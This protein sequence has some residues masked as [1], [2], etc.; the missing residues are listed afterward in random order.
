MLAFTTVPYVCIFS[1]GYKILDAAN[2][3]NL[4]MWAI[5]FLFL[6]SFGYRR[7]AYLVG[8]YAKDSNS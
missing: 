5:I 2:F 3:L 7:H 4:V 6:F 8:N 1:Y